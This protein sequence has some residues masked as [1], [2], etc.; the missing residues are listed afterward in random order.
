MLPDIF[1]ILVFSPCAFS[2]VMVKLDAP[3]VRGIVFPSNTVGEVI[4][5]GFDILLV[6][7]VVGSAG[8]DIL[9]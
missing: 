1:I 3:T 5:I 9:L 7:E 2:T 4:S 8:G 6:G